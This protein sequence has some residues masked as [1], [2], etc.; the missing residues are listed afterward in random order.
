[1]GQML[2]PSKVSHLLSPQGP[3]QHP[4]LW[5]SQ[6]ITGK[7]LSEYLYKLHICE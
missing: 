5:P 2:T 4:K 1:V 3:H 6:S 7:P